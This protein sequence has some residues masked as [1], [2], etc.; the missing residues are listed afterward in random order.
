MYCG[1]LRLLAWEVHDKLLK[2]GLTCNLLT[3]QETVQLSGARHCS[4]TIEMLDLVP[5]SFAVWA[6]ALCTAQLTP[7]FGGCRKR[8]WMW[9]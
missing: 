5:A 4:S 6:V 3:G 1:P 2:Q 9:Q 8:W 7:V